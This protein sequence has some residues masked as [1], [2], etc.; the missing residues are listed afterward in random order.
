MSKSSVA[1][2]NLRGFVILLVVAFHSVLAYL[3]SQ[4]H[5]SAPFDSPPYRWIA[6][7]ILDSERWFGFDLFCAFLYVYLMHFMF[8]LSGLFVWS[9]LG[10]KGV[11]KFL[12]DRF[13]RLGLPF[14]IGVYLLMP[15]AH[16]PVY[17]VTAVDPSW[18]AFW[19]HWI[20]LPFWPSGPLWFLWELLAFNIIAAGLFSFAP[21]CGELLGRLSANAGDRPGRYFAG[22]VAISGLAYVPLAFMFR[23]WEWVQL[24]PFAMQPSFALPYAIYFFAGLG[25]G[26]FGVERGLLA[27]NARLAQR[28]PLWVV[29]A[30]GAF[31]LWML[32]TALIVQGWATSVPGLEVLADIGLVLA[33]ATISLALA[34]VF[35]RFATDPWPRFS[36][37]SDNAYGIY[38][39]HYVFVIWLQYLLLGVPM[40]AIAKAAIVFTGTFLLSWG[41]AAA[42]CR[43]PFGARVIG[44]DR[45]ILV[46]AR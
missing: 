12:S 27:S 21:H 36:S 38:L 43:V 22:L 1:L 5:T 40:F 29:G 44:V 45:R 13:L 16:Y 35:V 30:L 34:A 39:L 25:V 2:R 10:R 8:F 9:S 11:W 18:A 23:P 42:V 24:G 37:F 7:P 20:A 17:R 46:R 41:G 28:W 14:L 19:S 32:P 26:A 31:V 15:V 6:F 3:G 4:P 33:C